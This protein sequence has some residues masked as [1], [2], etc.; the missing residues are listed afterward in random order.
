MPAYC[1]KY[2][3][4]C[5]I[6]LKDCQRS[7]ALASAVLEKVELEGKTPKQAQSKVPRYRNLEAKN[8][9]HVLFSNTFQKSAGTYA[10]GT[11]P[12][13][14]CFD[15]VFRPTRKKQSDKKSG[16]TEIDI[17]SRVSGGPAH[18]SCSTLAALTPNNLQLR[19]P[20]HDNTGSALFPVNESVPS[21][22]HCCRTNTVP[23]DFQ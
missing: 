18:P 3:A 15:D 6:S 5:Q 20:F 14:I 10:F 16:V 19:R 12:Y 13:D 1:A 9:G 23:G 22:P 11:S 2:F 7:C 4:E 8:L 17:G 21:S